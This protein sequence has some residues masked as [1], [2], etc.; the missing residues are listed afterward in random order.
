MT[1]IPTKEECIELLRKNNVPDNII[2]HSSAVCDFSMKI[3]DI[4]EKR[5]INVD[6]DLV[7]AAAL[8]HDVK[9]LAPGEHEIE[10]ASY[11]ESFGF[12]EVAILIKKHGLKRCHEDEFKPKTWEE[13]IIFYSDK[14]IKNDKTVSVDERFE[15]IKQKYKR[16]VVD[17]EIKLT[18]KIEK[19][20]LGDEKYAKENII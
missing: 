16:G 14:R 2:A 12:P 15:Y 4:L 6:R 3:C 1:K 10:G 8:L 19:E 20:L 11:A 9:K 17:R 13:K 5:G 18:K 7:A